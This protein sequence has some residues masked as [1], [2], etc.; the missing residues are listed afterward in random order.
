MVGL[1]P[2]SPWAREGA[3]TE[4]PVWV[5]MEERARR[6]AT[7]VADPVEEPPGFTEGSPGA[8]AFS[9]VTS[10]SGVRARVVARGP[11]CVFPTMMPP[12]SWRRVTAGAVHAGTKS[13]KMWELAVVG[14]PL[15]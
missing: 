8:Q 11:I 13:R 4:P 15:V 9:V 14:T 3:V 12:S 10:P 5:P 7:A 2:V 1:R 6:A